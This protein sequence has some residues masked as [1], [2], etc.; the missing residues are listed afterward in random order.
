VNKL[1][2]YLLLTAALILS[3]C[4]LKLVDGRD[5]RAFMTMDQDV[6]RHCMNECKDKVVDGYQQKDGK[7]KCV[8]KK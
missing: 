2:M 6:S 8:C 4:A 1:R 5:T 3:G 7:L